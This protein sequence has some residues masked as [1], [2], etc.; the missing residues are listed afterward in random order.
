ME[1]KRIR[2]D[3]ASDLVKKLEAEVEKSN[4]DLKEKKKIDA[5]LGVLRDDKAVEPEDMSVV[6]PPRFRFPSHAPKAVDRTDDGVAMAAVTAL[7][8]ALQAAKPNNLDDITRDTLTTLRTVE[9]KLENWWDGDVAVFTLWQSAPLSVREDVAFFK[10]LFDPAGRARVA[11]G[12]M[13]LIKSKRIK[14]KYVYF[15]APGVTDAILRD[16]EVVRTLAALY[17][18]IDQPHRMIEAAWYE[19]GDSAHIGH[20]YIQNAKAVTTIDVAHAPVWAGPFVKAGYVFTPDFLEELL[21]ADVKELLRR[22]SLDGL[23][24]R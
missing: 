1:E 8:H 13:D 17:N 9:V 12:Y 16:D 11:S 21:L 20:D 18:S 7:Y 24:L 2:L 6:F 4:L 3:L 19:D 5:Y 10:S 23:T 15:A 14:G 22:D